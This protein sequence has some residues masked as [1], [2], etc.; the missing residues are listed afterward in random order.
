MLGRPV[1]LL[2]PAVAALLDATVLPLVAATELA[3]TEL[4]ATEL[5]LALVEALLLLLVVAPPDP[6]VAV[7]S[8]ELAP[9]LPPLPPSKS[10]PSPPVAQAATHTMAAKN[11]TTALC[12][13]SF[14]MI[15]SYRKK[16]RLRNSTAIAGT[17]RRVAQRVVPPRLE[18]RGG[19]TTPRRMARMAWLG[20]ACN[21]LMVPRAH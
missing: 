16:P 1:P 13:D 19:P 10:A 7:L 4:A 2:A 8:L 12:G 3:A 11:T 5:A 15:Q 17:I 20:R 14:M 6:E 21:W 18:G 9:P